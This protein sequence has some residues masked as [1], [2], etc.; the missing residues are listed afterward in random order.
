MIFASSGAIDSIFLAAWA[1]TLV[2]PPVIARPPTA[3]ANF[4]MSRRESLLEERIDPPSLLHL[5]ETPA[6]VRRT[7]FV[8][9]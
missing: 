4:I 3:P 9:A 5:K 1:K 7:D 2:V 8:A 6:G